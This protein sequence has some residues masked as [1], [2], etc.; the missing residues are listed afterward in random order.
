[1]LVACGLVREA[2]IIARPGFVVVA[3]GGDSAR[4]ERE[5]EAAVAGASMVLSCGV[6]GALDPALRAGDVIVGTLHTSRSPHHADRFPGEGRGPVEEHKSISHGAQLQPPS[7][8]GPGLRRGSG[9][10]GA[11][12]EWLAKNLP[13]AQRGTV[14]GA[15]SIIGSVP[16]KTALHAATGAIAVDMESHIA[17]RVAARHDLP[18]AIVRTISDSADHALPPAALV[19]MTPDGGVALGAILAS[20]A[21]NPAQ[22]PALIRTGR[23]AGAAFKALGRALD[24]MEAQGFAQF[25][26]RMP[27]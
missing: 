14:V 19:G 23:D 17:A 20:L 2:A 16:A 4:L 3:G 11:L 9:V 1:M 22:L 5:L 15:D 8:L 21:R 24:L 18:F 7:R 25:V 10:G 13:D 12:V 26:A 27:S 6:A